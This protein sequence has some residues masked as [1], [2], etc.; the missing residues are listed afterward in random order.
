MRLTYWANNFYESLLPN[1]LF[2]FEGIIE[3]GI[4]KIINKVNFFYKTTLFD[5]L[6]QYFNNNNSK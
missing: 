4:K 6:L 3:F 2:Q 5:Q 1:I